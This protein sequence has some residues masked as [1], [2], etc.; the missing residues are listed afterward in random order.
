MRP[1]LSSA[2]GT[3][4]LICLALLLSSQA[5]FAH[6]ASDSYLILRTDAE[7]HLSGEWQLA[8][9]DL[10]DML[11][12]DVNED[13]VITWGELRT[14]RQAVTSFALF[15]LTI[16]ADQSI[17]ETHV[18][19]LLAEE[20]SDGTYA[21]L[22]LAMPTA[23]VHS[24]L[25]VKYDAFFT[26]DP[27]HRGL[28]RIESG[29]STKVAIFSP[30]AQEQTFDLAHDSEPATLGSFIDEGV[31]HIWTG[32]DHIL[33]LIALLLPGVLMRQAKHWQP[34]PTAGPIWSEV[35]KTVTAFTLAHS[36]TLSLATL[37]FV[38][39]PV[40]LV[41]SAI[42]A[43]VLAAGLNNLYP[44]LP[45]RTWLVAFSFGLLHGFGFAS[46]LRELGLGRGALAVPLF[47]FNFGVELGQLAIVLV[48]LPFAVAV[49]H[50]GFYRRALL[51]AGSMGIA[52][53]AANWLVER[54]CGL[55][56]L[57]F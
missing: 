36:L 45:Q 25:S 9:R 56:L 47:G 23:V 19:D 39:P 33:F 57:P 35:L 22:Q 54:S 30:T 42:A 40:R 15:H 2:F 37:G 11:G 14:H 41:E 44:I 55:Q 28:L 5:T 46:A 10:D 29:K 20:H 53:L 12:L 17:V 52:A 32:Y 1:L 8:L 38:Q 51:P 3:S 21:V 26:V 50:S 49:R 6:K 48:F 4:R 18:T 31:I 27:L 34:Q 16:F 24:H 43:S 7:H 13:G